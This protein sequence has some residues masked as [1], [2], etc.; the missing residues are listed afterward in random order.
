MQKL[1][2]A[3]VYY[4]CQHSVCCGMPNRY[5]EKSNWLD[6]AGFNSWQVQQNFQTCSGAH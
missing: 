2:Q 6:E 3:A 1:G 5:P 4:S